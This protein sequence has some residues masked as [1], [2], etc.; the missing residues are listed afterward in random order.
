MVDK[1]V[2][3]IVNDSLDSWLRDIPG[4][5]RGAMGVS[6]I[7]PLREA[8]PHGYMNNWLFEHNVGLLRIRLTRWT[9]VS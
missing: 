6:P 7:L 5:D 2:L 4:R 8:A 3:Y 1:C 9:T